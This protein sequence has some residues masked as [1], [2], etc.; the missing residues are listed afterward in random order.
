MQLRRKNESFSVP[1]IVEWL[2]ADPITRTKRFASTRVPYC[3]RKV[4]IQVGGAVRPPRFI[5]SQHQ[6]C[7]GPVAKLH[8]LGQQLGSQFVPIREP[9]IHH[10]HKALVLIRQWLRFLQRF[11][12]C[13]QHALAEGDRAANPVFDAVRP[14]IGHGCRHLLDEALLNRR[15]IEANYSCDATHRFC[16][17]GGPS[18]AAA[19]Q[20]REPNEAF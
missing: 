20:P 6:L 18:I 14:A 12:C 15:A 2:I 7:I 19:E 5:G 17:R 4:P 11:R 8:A 1:V 10:E 3:E 13:A 16:F 9:P